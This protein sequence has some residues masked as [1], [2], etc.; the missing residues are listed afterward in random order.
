MEVQVDN[1]AECFLIQPYPFPSMYGIFTYIYH[2]LSLKTTKRLVIFH[3][4]HGCYG[5][6]QPQK[7]GIVSSLVSFGSMPNKSNNNHKNSTMMG[8]GWSLHMGVPHSQPLPL[9]A[10]SS[11]HHWDSMPGKWSKIFPSSSA[12]RSFF[13]DRQAAMLDYG[14]E[15]SYK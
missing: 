11:C 10:S 14:L 15:R 6:F 8:S 12:F 5:I 4:V 3:T 2:V 13:V 1:S 9:T 7:T